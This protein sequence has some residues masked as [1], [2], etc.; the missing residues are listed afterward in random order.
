MAVAAA[1][2]AAGLVVGILTAPASG[3][4]TRRRWS[5]RIEDEANDMRRKGRHLMDRLS[6]GS[7]AKAERPE[8]HVHS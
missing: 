4:E 2:G 3:Q 6:H 1:A 8:T 7:A 5:R